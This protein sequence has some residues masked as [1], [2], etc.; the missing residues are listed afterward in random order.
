VVLVAVPCF[1]MPGGGASI[2]QAYQRYVELKPSRPS[3]GVWISYD[4][5]ARKTMQDD[6]RRL[7]DTGKFDDLSIT[8]TDYIFLNGVIGKFVTY[9]AHER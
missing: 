4:D 1:E 3:D 5:Y 8:V 2:P 9:T 7:W 6:Y